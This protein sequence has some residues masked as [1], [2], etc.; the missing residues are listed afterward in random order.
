MSDIRKPLTIR[1][2]DEVN[3]PGLTEA[4]WEMLRRMSNER[5]GRRRQQNLAASA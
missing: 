2:I 5:Q 3:P 4:Q 1:V